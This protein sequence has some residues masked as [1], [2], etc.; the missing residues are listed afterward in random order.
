M[1]WATKKGRGFHENIYQRDS[2]YLEGG[3][4][5]SDVR[6][7]P[8]FTGTE[9]EGEYPRQRT[10]LES[11]RMVGGRTGMSSWQSAVSARGSV[12]GRLLMGT[13]WGRPC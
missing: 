8:G 5:A 2:S 1:P 12:R 6:T 13:G 10:A 11:T 7:A 3:Q 9:W 4:G